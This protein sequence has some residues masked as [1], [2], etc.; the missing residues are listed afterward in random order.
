MEFVELGKFCSLPTCRQKDFLPFT[1]PACGIVTCREHSSYDN[2]SCPKRPDATVVKCT[3]CSQ[4][5]P[6]KLGQS[7]EVQI[8]LHLDRGCAK[9]SIRSSKKCTVKNCRSKPL[10]GQII[11]CT[12]CHHKVCLRHRFPDDHQCTLRRNKGIA[13]CSAE[14]AAS[15]LERRSS[16]R[17]PRGLFDPMHW[18][19]ALFGIDVDR[20]L[21][22]TQD[23]G[24]ISYSPNHHIISWN[25]HTQ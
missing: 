7:P 23:S 11:Q 16:L 9:N 6:I 4:F 1:C 10:A 14:V 24:W 13:S 21:S 5:I 19:H 18:I 12:K 2:H 3:S 20:R 15:T 8:K 25:L 17:L 22:T